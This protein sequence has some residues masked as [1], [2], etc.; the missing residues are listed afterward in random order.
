MASFELGVAAQPALVD[1]P[2]YKPS[3]AT[4]HQLTKT[5]GKGD[6]AFV[7]SGDVKPRCREAAMEPG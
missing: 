6:Q 3:K 2:R 4:S 7:G 1:G 5:V